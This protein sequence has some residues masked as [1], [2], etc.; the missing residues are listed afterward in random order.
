[1]IETSSVDFSSGLASGTYSNVFESGPSFFQVGTAP[2]TDLTNE[3]ALQFSTVNN[4]PLTNAGGVLSIFGGETFCSNGDCTVREGFGG[5]GE[6][7]I[8]AHSAVPLPAAAWL[9]GSA[10][11]GLGAVKRLKV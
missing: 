4:V 8:T 5:L 7:T 1:M 9:F 3:W 2:L 10:L 6:G 11:L